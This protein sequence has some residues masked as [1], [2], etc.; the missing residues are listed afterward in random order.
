[1]NNELKEIIAII[2]PEKWRATQQAIFEAGAT[3]VSQN[4]VL[5]RGRQAGLRYLGNGQTKGGL[6]TMDY[7]PKRMLSCV[8]ES[9]KVDAVVAGILRVNGSG[10]HGDGKIF[11]CPVGEVVR[12]RTSER[13]ATAIS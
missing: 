13:G 4:R 9:E 12:L 1:M 3:G 2:R 11:V 7:L 8:V 10:N 6:V 5:G